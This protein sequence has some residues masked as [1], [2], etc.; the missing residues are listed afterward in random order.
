VSSDVLAFVELSLGFWM[1][2]RLLREEAA[3][4]L[5][6]GRASPSGIRCTAFSAS[7]GIAWRVAASSRSVISMAPQT[8]LAAVA[9][10]ALLRKT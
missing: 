2:R 6:A 9:A 3:A 1:R 5:V 10:A 8:G 4:A 7:A